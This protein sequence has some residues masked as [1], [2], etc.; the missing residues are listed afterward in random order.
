MPAPNTNIYETEQAINGYLAQHPDTP[1][2][3]FRAMVESPLLIEARRRALIYAVGHVPTE[4]GFPLQRVT[5]EALRTEVLKTMADN[6]LDAF[7]YA[8]FDH[9]PTKL[10]HTTLGNNELAPILGFPALAVPGGFS[11]DGL[12]LGF[13]FL[14]MPFSEGTLFKAAYDFEQSTKIRRPPAV[15]PALPK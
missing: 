3:T 5:Q 1:V 11:S 10:P 6:R 14:G 8:T 9:A 12:P 13:E 4:P 7:L 2:R 15:T